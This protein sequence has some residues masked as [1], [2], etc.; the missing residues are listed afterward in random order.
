MRGISRFKSLMV[1]KHRILKKYEILRDFFDILTEFLIKSWLIFLAKRGF[2]DF[3]KMCQNLLQ[4]LSQ[5]LLGD[6]KKSTS[7]RT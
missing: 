1:F 3:A 5:N 4:N 7:Q 2:A 6:D